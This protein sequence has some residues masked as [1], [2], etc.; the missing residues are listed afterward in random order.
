MKINLIFC[1]GPMLF[2]CLVNASAQETVCASGGDASGT[3]GTVAYSI[4]QVAFT[5]LSGIGGSI[6]EGVQQT[7]DDLGLQITTHGYNY[8]IAVFPNPCVDELILKI[9]D[10]P[11]EKLSYL[12]YD[13]R[14]TLCRSG[15]ISGEQSTIQISDLA[16][17]TYEL[18]L[19]QENK[20]IKSFTIIKN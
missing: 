12:L 15:M 19:L 17:S 1:F 5:Q 7:Y 13:M 9:Q 2:G 20:N 6:N 8:S 11:T 18:L 14:G 4:G 16:P 3:G 10:L